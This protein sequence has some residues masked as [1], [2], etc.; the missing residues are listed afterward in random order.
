MYTRSL[1]G[2]IITL[3]HRSALYRQFDCL[4]FLRILCTRTHARTHTHAHTHSG[5]P[6]S[7]QMVYCSNMESGC[8]KV[9]PPGVYGLSNQL[10][11][12]PWKKVVCGKERFVEIVGGIQPS[13]TKQELTDQLMELLCTSTW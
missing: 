5:N 8:M 1:E 4:G 10:L 13:T 9:L 12:S 7:R 3:Q 6:D 2:I 11:D